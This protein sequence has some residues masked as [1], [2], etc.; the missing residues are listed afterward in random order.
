MNPL[1]VELALSSID[2]THQRR[3]RNLYV[4]LAVADADTPTCL[5]V[6][7]LPDTGSLT[8]G[9]HW[10]QYAF[11][12]PV[13][14]SEA[15]SLFSM[16]M[17]AS[18]TLY[19]RMWVMASMDARRKLVDVLEGIDQFID[20][21]PEKHELF[22]VPGGPSPLVIRGFDT[23]HEGLAKLGIALILSGDRQLGFVSMDQSFD[24]ANK[25]VTRS[26]TMLSGEGTVSWLWTVS[27]AEPI[28]TESLNGTANANSLD[29]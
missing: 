15:L 28:L 1:T 9:K 13:D 17:P 20:W 26:Q 10:T 3:E 5:A 7:H 29:L 18:K 11:T 2:L 16:P 14:A 27:P 24:A 4:V 21:N 6:T 8:L 23:A 19:V 22:Q 12:P 25:P